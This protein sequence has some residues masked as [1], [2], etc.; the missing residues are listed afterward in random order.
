LV[1]LVS[2]GR[3]DQAIV[4][5]VPRPVERA[6]DLLNR[7]QVEFPLTVHPLDP[8]LLSFDITE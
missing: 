2:F 8:I 7:R 4:L 1:S 6:V 5:H 3:R